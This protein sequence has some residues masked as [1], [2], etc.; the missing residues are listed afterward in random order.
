MSIQKQLD[1]SKPERMRA[2]LARPDV[3]PIVEYLLKDNP[4]YPVED[5]G[6]WAVLRGESDRG[7]VLSASA[8]LD[9]ALH[10]L[11][12]AS[13]ADCKEKELLVSGANAPVS[14]FAARIKL[15]YCMGMLS[16]VVFRDLE[17]IRAIRNMFAHDYTL[18]SLQLPVLQNA[19]EQLECGIAGTGARNQLLTTA[20]FIVGD[21]RNGQQRAI[22]P[23]VPPDVVLQARDWFVTA[24]SGASQQIPAT[25]E[26]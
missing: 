25:T 20:L 22:Q 13:L 12:R 3:R 19:C 10:Q 26:P 16:S 23:T 21:L 1:K 5:I 18:D 24:I 17:R 2:L 9:D 8:Y 6:L 4:N 7:A 15:S 14:S 11:L